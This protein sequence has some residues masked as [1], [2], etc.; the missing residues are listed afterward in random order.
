MI[1][2]GELKKKLRLMA[3]SGND[4]EMFLALIEFNLLKY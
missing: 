4:K 2:I 3:N 1:V